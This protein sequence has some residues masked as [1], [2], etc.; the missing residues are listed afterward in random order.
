M[1]S[2]ASF[3]TP[4]LA[5]IYMDQGQYRQAAGIYR[6]LLDQDPGNSQMAQAL[7]DARKKALEQRRRAL[8]VLFQRW[9]DL[10]EGFNRLARL[11]RLGRCRSTP[12]PAG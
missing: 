1:T 4:T 5:R 12:K 8:A 10:M 2:Q 9:F 7:D 11:R 3:C 6:H